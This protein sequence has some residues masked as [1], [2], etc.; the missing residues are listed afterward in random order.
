MIDKIARLESQ[1]AI[2]RFMG[3]AALL[4]HTIFNALQSLVDGEYLAI[5][6]IDYGVNYYK[7]TEKGKEYL[8]RNYDL[9]VMCEYVDTI[10]DS[11]FFSK[12]LQ[13]L[14]NRDK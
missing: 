7:V 14:E 1:Y 12:I 13:Q 6:K 3:K 5:T 10:D 9:R 11:Q 4:P 2:M 8:N